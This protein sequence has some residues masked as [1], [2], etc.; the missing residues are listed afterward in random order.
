MRI[1][2]GKVFGN[3]VIVEGEALPEGSEVT[4]WADDPEG[5]DLDDG[6]I[7]ELSQADAACTRREARRRP[8]GGERHRGGRALVGGEPASCPGVAPRP[9]THL[10]DAAHRHPTVAR[11][12]SGRAPSVAPEDT[13]PALLPRAAAVAHEPVEG[14]EVVAWVGSGLDGPQCVLSTRRGSIA[15]AASLARSAR[16]Y[17]TPV[18]PAPRR[19]S[20][21]TL[22]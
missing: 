8:T 2:R 6:S 22:P 15:S 20:D 3:T 14:T 13:L 18:A 21:P 12:A 16:P 17:S 4:I 10:D 11:K 7:E 9:A 1:A 5:F 19:P